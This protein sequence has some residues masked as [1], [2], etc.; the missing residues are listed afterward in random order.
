VLGELSLPSSSGLSTQ[1]GIGG[2]SSLKEGQ[3]F[4]DD[5]DNDGAIGAGQGIDYEDELEAIEEDDDKHVKAEALSPTGLYTMK[6][7]RVRIVKKMVERP[8][9]VYERFPAFEQDKILDFSELFKGYAVN[10]S[11]IKRSTFGGA[12]HNVVVKSLA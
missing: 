12:S 11:R 8:K 1:L 7:R 3:F 10:K 9:T 6:E 2:I 5:W 4:R